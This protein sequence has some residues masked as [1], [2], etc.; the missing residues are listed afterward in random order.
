MAKARNSGIGRKVLILAAAL[1]VITGVVARCSALHTQ[2]ADIS[3]EIVAAEENGPAQEDEA[4]SESTEESGAPVELDDQMAEIVDG[5]DEQT[6]EAIDFLR[7]NAWTT[8]DSAHSVEFGD[9]WYQEHSAS[10]ES[11]PVAY[12]VTALST[13][14]QSTAGAVVTLTTLAMQTSKGGQIVTLGKSSDA[15]GEVVWTVSS[16][17]FGG[18]DSYLRRDKATA[19]A[20]QGLSE[21]MLGLINNDVEG[22]DRALTEYCR[23]VYPQASTATWEQV[24]TVDEAQGAIGFSMMLDASLTPSVHVLY[25][26]AK[27]VFEVGRQR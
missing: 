11:E 9:C 18:A 19:V 25:D 14:Q 4:G 10:G 26:E 12:A 1:L 8:F 23:T 17:G 5:Y 27:G 7:S 6:I 24:A 3:G 20:S 13:T 22:L 16:D 15:A 21:R 2:D